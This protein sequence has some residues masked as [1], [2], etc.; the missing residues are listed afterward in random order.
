MVLISNV[1]HLR[2]NYQTESDKDL[3]HNSLLLQTRLSLALGASFILH[4]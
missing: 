4:F 1:L 3:F 2:V